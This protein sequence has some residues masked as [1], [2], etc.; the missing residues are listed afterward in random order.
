LAGLALAGTLAIGTI[1]FWLIGTKMEKLAKNSIHHYIVCGMGQMGLH[2]VD[3]LL[4]TKRAHVIID[5][6]RDHIDKALQKF[7]GE[8]FVVGD[9]TDSDTLLKAGIKNAKESSP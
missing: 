3:E 7:K 6:N 8:V 1:G 2:I 9:A 5:R 4:T